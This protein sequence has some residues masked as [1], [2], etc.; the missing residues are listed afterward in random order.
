M[1]MTV[2]SWAAFT[3]ASALLLRIPAATVPLVVSYALGQGWRTAL[4]MAVGVALAD[5]TAMTGSMPGLGALLS[6][7]AT[8]F[9]VLKWAGATCLAYLGIKF[10]RGGETLQA[11]PRT[12]TASTFAGPRN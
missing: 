11:N 7:S 8:L 10:W 6:T 5:F 3:A 4:P 9:T 12:Y 2:E 1:H